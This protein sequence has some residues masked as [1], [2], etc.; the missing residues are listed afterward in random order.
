VSHHLKVLAEAGLLNR[1]Q[2]GTWAWY[3]I[4]TQRLAELSAVLQ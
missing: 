2:R 4:D 1:E 3:S